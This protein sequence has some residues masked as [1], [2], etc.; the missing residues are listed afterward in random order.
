MVNPQILF[1]IAFVLL[2]VD[3][4]ANVIVY[5]QARQVNVFL[6]EHELQH[7]SLEAENDALWQETRDIYTMLNVQNRREKREDST[8]QDLS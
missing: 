2:L 6:K 1:V 8:Q 3:I 4:T 5:F 7:F